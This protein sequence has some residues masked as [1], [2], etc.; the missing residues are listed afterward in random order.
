MAADL[1]DATTGT[2]LSHAR[3]SQLTCN[4]PGLQKENL[5]SFERFLGHHW[6]HYNQT[7]TKG[8]GKLYS[9]ETASFL[10]DHQSH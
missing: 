2:N 6:P 8:L 10:T 4:D 9:G 3:A 7:L 5:M 1:V